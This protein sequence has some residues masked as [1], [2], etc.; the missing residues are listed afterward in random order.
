MRFCPECGAECESGEEECHECRFPLALTVRS[1]LS[2]VTIGRDQAAR[3]HRI[4]AWLRRSGVVLHQKEA[5]ELPRGQYW[6]ALPGVGAFIFALTLLFGQSLVDMIWEPPKPVVPVVD[7]NRVN[8][9][10]TP[11][12]SAESAD[13]QTTALMEALSTTQEQRD[14]TEAWQAESTVPRPK[15]RA[16]LPKRDILEHAR[17]ATLSVRVEGNQAKGALIGAD[18]RFLVPS[19]LVDAA[20][21][22]E[23]RNVAGSGSLEQKMVFIQPEVMLADGRWTPC[24][25]VEALP[26]FG[27]T[28]LQYSGGEGLADT[29]RDFNVSLDL[30]TKL[31]LLQDDGFEDLLEVRVDNAVANSFEINFWTLDGGLGPR[32]RGA[33]AFDEQGALVGVYTLVGD[34]H[35]V[36]SLRELRERAPG[37]YRQIR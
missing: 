20:F 5:T 26:E 11:R 3:W 16:V 1:G 4:A 31:F 30:G 6:W 7:L 32:G 8:R 24:S 21:R 23:K 15:D 33:P 27:L 9:D 22:T 36:V 17:R 34:R 29:K 19:D 14:L 12:Q 37:S 2:G 10:G 25:Q 35:A 18:G 28:L 13:S